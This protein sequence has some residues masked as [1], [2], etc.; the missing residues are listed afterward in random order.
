MPSAE[1]RGYFL[2]YCVGLPLL[3][4]LLAQSQACTNDKDLLQLDLFPGHNSHFATNITLSRTVRD[5]DLFRPA[6]MAFKVAVFVA[7]CES[8]SPAHDWNINPRRYELHNF[9]TAAVSSS[10]LCLFCA[11]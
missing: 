11:C 3:V 4:N 5:T 2:R 6:T 1:I 8:S 7:P 10:H 9:N